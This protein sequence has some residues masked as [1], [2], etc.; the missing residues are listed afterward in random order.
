VESKKS[1]TSHISY[2]GQHGFSSVSSKLARGLPEDINQTASDV[3]MDASADKKILEVRDW[4][5]DGSYRY[6][7][8][9]PAASCI[10]AN[11]SIGIFFITSFPVQKIQKIDA[12]TSVRNRKLCNFHVIKDNGDGLFG[13]VTHDRLKILCG[14]RFPRKMSNVVSRVVNI[15]LPVEGM[16]L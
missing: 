1:A 16:P 6:L 11:L 13:R 3:S 4:R 5:D 2:R 15:S 7:V 14:F 8:K 12:G 9:P 10:L